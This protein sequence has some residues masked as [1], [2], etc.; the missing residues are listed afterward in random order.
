MNA[1]SSDSGMVAATM[2]PGADVV[3]E[4]DQDHDDQQDPAEQVVL[5]RAGGEWIRSLR[6]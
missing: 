4:E 6:S 2:R 5:H 1:N 3:E